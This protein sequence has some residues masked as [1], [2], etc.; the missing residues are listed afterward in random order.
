MAL[1]HTVLK[2]VVALPMLPT[3][4]PLALTI[5]PPVILPVDTVRLV[6]VMAAPVM[7][8]VAD[9]NPAVRKLPP[10]MFPVALLYP[11]SCIYNELY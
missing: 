2:Y 6:P 3:P 10:C 1:A 11:F 9:T 4:L 5:L 7:A 8:P